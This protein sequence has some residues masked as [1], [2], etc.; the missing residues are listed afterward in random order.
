MTNICVGNL[1]FATSEDEIRTLF[2]TYGAIKT[3]TA[4][5]DQWRTRGTSQ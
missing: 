3:A 2:A 5:K 4:V 1:D